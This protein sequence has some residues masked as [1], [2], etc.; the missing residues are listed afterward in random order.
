MVTGSE[1]GNAAFV[2]YLA[3]NEG[4]MSI[5]AFRDHSGDY[6]ER[7]M[8]TPEP[9]VEKYQLNAKYRIPLW[10]LVFHDCMVS[11]WYWGDNSNK[12]PTQWDRRDQLNALYGTPP[13]FYFDG[14]FWDKNKARFQQSYQKITPIARATGYS[15]MTDFQYLSSD[16]MVQ[17]TAFSNGVRVIA[18]FGPSGYKLA[19]GAILSPGSIVSYGV[20]DALAGVNAPAT[21]AATPTAS[22]IRIDGKATAFP[23]YNING[24]NYV[25]L[26]DL[27]YSLQDTQKGY[28]VVWNPE[29]NTVEVHT[30]ARYTPI[31][32][33]M[34]RSSL[35]AGVGRLTAP[36]ILCDG[37]T[38]QLPAYSI[39]QSNYVRL[40]DMASLL[41]FSV[42]YDAKENRIVIDTSNS[43]EVQR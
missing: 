30:N 19:D 18:N 2:P 38:V 12:Y 3:Y 9:Q 25:K 5:G 4:M 14:P 35:Q 41:D 1:N 42:T 33:E 34:G 26:R 37:I 16:R 23:A 32:G 20:K 10:E 40:R 36:P 28:S 39:L 21:G 43:Y 11:Y 27:A 22:Q 24:Y 7:I 17:F 6:P 31:G 8:M 15:E 29:K 13:M